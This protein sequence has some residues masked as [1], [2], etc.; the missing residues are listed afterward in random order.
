MRI[1]NDRA[2]AWIEEH[3]SALDRLRLTTLL[4]ETTP[5]AVPDEIR[6]LQNSD[7]GF[8]VG[9][10]A[11]RPS[12]L[13][14]TAYVLAW[15][16]DLRLTDSAEAGRALEFIIKRQ[17]PRG[18]WRE[19]RDVQRFDP[20]PWM[21]PESTAADI[22]TTALCAGTVAAL[23][24]DDLPPEMAVVWLQTQQQ[25]DGLLAGF[26]AHSSWLA[27]PAFATVLGHETR[28]TRRLIAGLGSI[29]DDSWPGSMLAWLL[30]SLLDGGYTRRTELVNRAALLLESA[31]QPDGSFTVDEGDDPA[32]TIL[33]AIDVAQ[34]LR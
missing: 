6:A 3:G 15:L 4:G 23:S 27:A 24:D 2:R 17:S 32:H 7:G 8:P 19:S 31:Q 22:Y 34:R 11:G 20:P 30:Q 25:Q 16:R 21:D 1:D 9:L 26:R 10:V 18:I 29:L 5:A 13:S 33:Q 14:P 12:A 28:A